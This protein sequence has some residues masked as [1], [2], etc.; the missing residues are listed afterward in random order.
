MKWEDQSKLSELRDVLDKLKKEGSVILVEGSQDKKS[1][2][3]LGVTNEIVKLSENS[4][5]FFE[6][7]E[8]IAEK[9]DNAIILTDW[10]AHGEKLSSKIHKLLQKNGVTPNDWYRRKLKAML[11]KEISDVESLY[12]YLGKQE[13]EKDRI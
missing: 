1:L 6:I 3:N 2:R 4:K 10:D 7:T 12:T 5:A 8:Q 11:L 13:K 9:Y